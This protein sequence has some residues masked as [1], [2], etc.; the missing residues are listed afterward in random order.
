MK[1]YNQK[2]GIYP[3]IEALDGYWVTYDQHNQSVLDANKLVEKSWRA[4]DSLALTDDIQ[5][6][7]M[8]NVIVVLS[9][10]CFVTISILFF[11][12]LS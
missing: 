2:D 6:E 1:R 4:R 11:I 9:I 3:M 5:M 7:K 12:G 8:C 10:V